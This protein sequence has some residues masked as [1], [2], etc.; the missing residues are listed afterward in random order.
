MSINTYLITLDEI[1]GHPRQVWCGWIWVVDG[2]EQ[3]WSKRQELDECCDVMLEVV[4]RLG[5]VEA[6]DLDA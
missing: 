2:V 1:K 5:Q 6:F 3:R 4:N